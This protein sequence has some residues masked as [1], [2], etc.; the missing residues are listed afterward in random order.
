MGASTSV[1]H[2]GTNIN[3]KYLSVTGTI[4]K[5]LK[6][7]CIYCSHY[8]HLK[9]YDIE[10]ALPCYTCLESL[11]GKNEEKF[12]IESVKNIFEIIKTYEMKD[13]LTERMGWVTQNEAI[14]EYAVKKNI[15]T[16]ELINSS[17]ILNKYGIKIQ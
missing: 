14:V 8:E 3:G 9:P 12:N 4:Y 7:G 17:Y 15:S 5:Q 10:L 11:R 1:I 2:E 6:C 16:I 13:L